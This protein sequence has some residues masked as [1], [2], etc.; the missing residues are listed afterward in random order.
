MPTI[1]VVT[2][3]T[4]VAARLLWLLLWPRLLLRLGPLLLRL[5]LRSLLLLL[6]RR[7]ATVL[8][9]VLAAA[10]VV[11]VSKLRCRIVLLRHRAVS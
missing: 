11:V 8:H 5:G 2:V 6:R 7:S 1:A 3:T 9:V 10:R 4:L